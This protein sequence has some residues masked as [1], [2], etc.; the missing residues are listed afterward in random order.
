MAWIRSTTSIFV[1]LALW[2]ALSWLFVDNSRLFP[3]PW[4]VGLALRNMLIS[5]ELTRDVLASGRRA[6][7]GFLI[8]SI[9]G[10]V[11]GYFTGRN[12]LFEYIFAGPLQVLRPLPPISL[13]PL[14]ILWFGIN[15]TS[16][17]TLVSF[18]AFFPVWISTH[19]GTSQVDQRLLWMAQSL[20]ASRWRM[21]MDVTLPAALPMIVS[22]LRTAIGTA[23]FCLVAAELA[24]AVDGIVFRINLS[25]LAFRVDR[26]IAGLIL[27]GL[28]SAICD[29]LFI[30]L[31]HRV[32]PW[33]N[34]IK[35]N[36]ENLAT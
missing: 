6:F 33:L 35:A 20:G 3:S 30:R 29:T 13:V 8:G 1:L 17:Y 26:I 7:V 23:F 27:L 18:G 25:H 9:A 22:G 4:D 34:T 24:G 5:G 32:F 28:L 15:E 21:A 36:H 10:M 11:V 19:L 12:R 31:I 14:F 2:I 16:K